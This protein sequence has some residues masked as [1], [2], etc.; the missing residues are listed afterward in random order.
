MVIVMTTIQVSEETH[1]ELKKIKGELLA[2]NGRE[3]TFDEI[4]MLLIEHYRKTL[5]HNTRSNRRL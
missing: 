5:C 4:I 2:K 3:R 1:T